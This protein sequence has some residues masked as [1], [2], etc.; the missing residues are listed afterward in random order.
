[1]RGVH[2]LEED[3]A[4]TSVP[5]ASRVDRERE[6]ARVHSR[7]RAAT[8]TWTHSDHPLGP[9]IRRVV[10]GN[11]TRGRAIALLVLGGATVLLG[12]AAWL[13]PSPT[14]V[15]THQQLGLAPCSMLLLG[16]VPCPT[17][18]MTTAFS[19]CVRGQW[20]SAIVVQPAGFV[21][22]LATIA[23]AFVSLAVLATGRVWVVNWYRIPPA[24]VAVCAV[25]LMLSSWGFKVLHG[26]GTGGLP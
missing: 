24:R 5:N 2:Y 17:C 19:H 20:I 3:M 11:R 22:A 8:K 1:M 7:T 21:L 16:G 12:V 18:G 6:G 4:E 26:I 25:V 13:T 15:G 23:A 14:G 9:L 10:V